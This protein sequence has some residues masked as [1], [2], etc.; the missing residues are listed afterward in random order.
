MDAAPCSS[1][2]GRVAGQRWPLSRSDGTSAHRDASTLP[3]V[4]PEQT[5]ILALNGGSSSIK[6][7]AYAA[8]SRERLLRVAIDRIG[9]RDAT[10]TL[11]DRTGLADARVVDA[12]CHADAAVL[13]LEVLEAAIPLSSVIGVGHR[14]VD[15]GARHTGP[16][17]ITDEL[18]DDLRHASR[19]APAHLPAEIAMIDIARKRM[20]R[21]V[22]VACFDS[23]FHRMMPRVAKNFPLPRRLQALGVE[24]RGFHGLSFAFLMQELERVAGADVS[25]G[26][27][28]LAHLGAGSSLAAVHEGVGID[29]TMGFTPA[30]GLPMGTRAG[31]LD[32]GLVLYLTQTEGM[33]A[34]QFDEM[35]NRQSGM[36][37]VSETSGD[38]RA[39]LAAEATDE[40]AA[41]ALAMFCYHVRKG[42]GAYAAALGGVE[43]LIFTG[44]IGENAPQIRSR[45][46]CGLEFL[47][48]QLDRGRNEASA[49]VI[50]VAEARVAVRVMRTDEEV[51]IAE[52]VRA[53][54][55][56]RELVEASRGSPG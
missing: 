15:G 49:A 31:D 54:L 36:L 9:Q 37:G 22:H 32:P 52:A 38:V 1:A 47:G 34:T 29:T 45:I 24:R 33:S 43:T 18:V 46:C 41:E 16:E 13:L 10:L 4:T 50:S 2:S 55:P 27:V 30:G 25:R 6:V 7:V 23:T 48:V 5:L 20:T 3:N 14:V 44:G 56:R 53:L 8:D 51:M 40:R 19:F 26:R 42:I 28:I 17:R 12:T 35:V 11:T 39:L 21:A